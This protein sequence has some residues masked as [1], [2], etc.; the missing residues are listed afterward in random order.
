MPYRRLPNTDKA[1]LRAMKTALKNQE[2]KIELVIPYNFRIK[3][4]E[5]AINFENKLI[6]KNRLQQQGIIYNRKHSELTNKARMYIS[7]FIQIVNM[8]IQ[9]GELCKEIRTYYGIAKNDTKVP[10]LSS[11]KKILEQG[12]KLIKGENERILKGGNRIYNPS[13]A[14][15]SINFEKFKESHIE[16]K[17]QQ[18]IQNKASGELIKYRQVADE[19]IVKLWNILEEYFQSD[20]ETNSREIC[21]MWGIHYVY[22]KTELEKLKRIHYESSISPTLKF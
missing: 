4:R 17:N 9:R 18:H 1:R 8:A 2:E 5:V 11:D 10:D 20:N 15:V 14:L 7:H 22:R 12:E 6:L 21:S 3:L 16:I 19:Y 13:L